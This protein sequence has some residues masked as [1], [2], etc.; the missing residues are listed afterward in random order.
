MLKKND[1]V[2]VPVFWMV[3][4]SEQNCAFIKI[5]IVVHFI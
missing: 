5:Y 1:I 4:F 3:S 2:V